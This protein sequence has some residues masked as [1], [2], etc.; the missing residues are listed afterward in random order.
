MATFSVLIVGGSV[1]GLALANMLERYGIEYTLIEKHEVVAPQLGA[2][3]TMLPQAAR[4]LDQLGC[5]GK[6]RT[7]GTPVNEGGLFGPDGNALNID[8]NAGDN[9]EAL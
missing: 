9:L 8:P 6:I 2:S 4:I 3:F 1:A 5:F 7:L